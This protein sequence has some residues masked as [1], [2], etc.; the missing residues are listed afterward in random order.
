MKYISIPREKIPALAG[1]EQLPVEA[2]IYKAHALPS[3]LAGP[4]RAEH[5]IR[6]IFRMSA[7]IFKIYLQFKLK[8]RRFDLFITFNSLV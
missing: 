6:S 4:G 5:Y 7:F 8:Y 3:E 1:F 2:K